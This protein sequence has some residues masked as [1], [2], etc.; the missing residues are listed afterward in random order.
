MI[1]GQGLVDLWAGKPVTLEPK[2][3]GGMDGTGHASFCSSGA[4]DK[5][6]PSVKATIQ[7]PPRDKIGTGYTGQLHLTLPGDAAREIIYP[8][9]P[10][11][12]ENQ[13]LC[14]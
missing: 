13:A 2:D 6:C 9:N 10:L 12:K 4:T 14:G 7:L 11:L 1:W 8:I 3:E 5:D